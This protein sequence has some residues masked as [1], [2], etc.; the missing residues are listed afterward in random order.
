MRKYWNN[1]VLDTRILVYVVDSCYELR[2]PESYLELHKLLGDDRLKRVPIVIV[3]NKQVRNSLLLRSFINLL[4]DFFRILM[5][6]SAYHRWSM[7]WGWIP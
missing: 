7:P 5:E 2:L 6:R 4:F 3:A 1:F